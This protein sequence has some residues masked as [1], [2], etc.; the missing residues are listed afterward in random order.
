MA[1]PGDP[2][3]P[4]THAYRRE[5]LVDGFW[6]MRSYRCDRLPDGTILGPADDPSPLEGAFETWRTYVVDGRVVIDIDRARF[7]SA[8]DL[9]YCATNER[10]ERPAVNLVAFTTTD[11]APGTV[12]SDT[13]FFALPVRSD[14]QVAA[15]RWWTDD[16]EMD[17][18]YVDREHRRLQVAAKLVRAAS[19]F[20]LANGWP[21]RLHDNGRH[22]DLGDELAASFRSARVAALRERMPPMD[23]P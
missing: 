15:I 14:Q 19:A 22:T 4:R 9:W 8:P 11:I 20:H 3:T 2:S 18:V 21:G 23:P 7:P 13:E 1:G 6:V 5:A 12:I 17:Q 16:G 10:D